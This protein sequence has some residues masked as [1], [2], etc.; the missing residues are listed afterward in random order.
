MK[1]LFSIF[2]FSVL[3]LFIS[4]NSS[5]KSDPDEIYE[6]V[7]ETAELNDFLRQKIGDWAEEGEICYGVVVLVDPKGVALEGMPVKA[8]I[9]RIKSDSI[10]MKSLENINL[11]EVEGCSQLG[12]SN[13]EKWWESE[14]DL[15]RTR[16]EAEAFLKGII[17]EEKGSG[18]FTI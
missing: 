14:G 17:K 15:F 10:K 18:K 6:Y 1:H 12:I 7:E 5:Q 11:R 16:E 4:C 8:R 3:A 2:T 13:G 9:L